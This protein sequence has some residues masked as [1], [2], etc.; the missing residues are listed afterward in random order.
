MARPDRLFRLLHALRTLPAPATAAQLAGV[1]EVS[2]RQLY[3]DIAALRAAGARIEGEAGYGYVLAEDPALPPQSFTRIEIEALLLGLAEVQ[4]SGDLQLAEAA[5]AVAAKITARLL[6]RQQR[7]AAHAVSYVYR[8]DRRP[9]PQR[10]IG[11]IRQACWDEVAL[12]LTY[13]DEDGAETQRRIWPLTIAYLDNRLLVLGW[14]HLRQ[15]YRKFRIDRIVTVTATDDSFRPRRVS[16]LRA[17][18]R[19]LEAESAAWLAGAEGAAS[20]S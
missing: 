10:D 4:A 8:H 6:E 13:R 12:D 14:C 20:T 19:G 16:M 11:V 5:T 7:E 9:V 2:P 3:R 18:V 1:T 17:Y 15:D